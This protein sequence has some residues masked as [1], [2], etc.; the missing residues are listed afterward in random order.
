[1]RRYEKGRSRRLL[2]IDAHDLI[3]MLQIFFYQLQTLKTTLDASLL[4]NLTIFRIKE[5]ILSLP[6]PQKRNCGNGTPHPLGALVSNNW[7]VNE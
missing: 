4:H 6:L 1:M 5:P 7:T 2:Y 3:S